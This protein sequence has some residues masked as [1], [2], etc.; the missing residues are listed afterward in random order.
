MLLRD[1]R[2]E[3]RAKNDRVP[4]DLE[5]HAIAT[6]RTRD[7][8]QAV[9]VR[10]LR[11]IGGQND[12]SNLHPGA[13]AGRAP[14][15]ARL[16]RATTWLLAAGCFW[17]VFGKIEAAAAKAYYEEHIFPLLHAG[18]RVAV[19][20]GLFANSDGNRSTQDLALRAKLLGF[21]E[22][23]RAEPRIVGMAPCEQT[24]L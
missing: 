2:H 20:P 15:R 23:I 1:V 21:E 4:A 3:G 12:V 9:L 10:D 11:A 22:W 7:G 17:L 18:Q 5:G 16:L 19:V 14:W 8:N 13:R 6:R 24:R